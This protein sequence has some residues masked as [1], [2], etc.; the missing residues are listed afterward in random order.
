MGGGGEGE[1][2]REEEDS[3]WMGLVCPDRDHPAT[4]NK[5]RLLTPLKQELRERKEVEEEG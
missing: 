3:R 4:L 1:T 2:E 5:S